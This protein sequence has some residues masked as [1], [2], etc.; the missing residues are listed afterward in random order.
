MPIEYKV[1]MV[2]VRWTQLTYQVRTIINVEDGQ[3]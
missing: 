3:T 2:E 1:R